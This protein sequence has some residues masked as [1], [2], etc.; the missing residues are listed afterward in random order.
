VPDD[1][2]GSR[3]SG[4]IERCKAGEVDVSEALRRHFII[5]LGQSQF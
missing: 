1:N 2:R 3:V 5:E 4:V